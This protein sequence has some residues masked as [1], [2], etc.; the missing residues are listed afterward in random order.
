MPV[1]RVRCAVVAIVV[2][3]ALGGCGNL[4]DQ[5]AGN[6]AANGTT[7]SRK[8][9]VS[10][11]AGPQLFCISNIGHTLVAF[12]LTQQQVLTNTRVYLDPD[13]VGPWFYNGTGYYLSRVETSGSGSNSLIAF[14]PKTAG[15]LQ[16]MKFPVNSNPTTLLQLP[17]NPGMAWVALRGSTFDN[18]ATNA[19]A[20]VDLDAW[21]YHQVDLNALAQPA[22]DDGIIPSGEKLTSLT[23][24]LWDA[25]CPTGGGCVYALVNN[26]D[27]TVRDHGWVL[28]LGV[29]GSGN[30][31][32]LSAVQ[33]GRNPQEDMLLDTGNGLLWV[34][35]NGGYPP[36]HEPGDIQGL[37]AAGWTSTT[38]NTV[39]DVPEGTSAG[40][41]T[42]LVGIQAF[43]SSTAWV[44]TYPSDAVYTL[45]LSA[46]TL[47]ETPG[48]PALTGPLFHTTAPVAG[49]YAAKGGYGL[50][51]LAELN[52]AAG[53]ALLADYNLQS[54]SGPA[55]CAETTVP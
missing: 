6:P 5:L 46:F 37:D 16:R 14:N 2:L 31:T 24:L 53:G 20:V 18:F 10:V 47:N 55:D 40:G 45:D 30:P 44:T 11:P 3:S 8:S 9:T 23:S 22:K 4:L 43:D 52:S 21:T 25:S 26:F 13:P 41:S 33:T 48:L 35:N 1:P 29:D 36:D 54:G 39:Q 17:S 27:G 49:L 12:D 50:A 28:A 42:A 34:V 19:I 32:L 38:W 7:D 51:H 15:E